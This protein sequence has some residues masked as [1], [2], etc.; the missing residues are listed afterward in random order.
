MSIDS[1]LGLL[2]TSL[3]GAL[4]VLSTIVSSIS[5]AL[6]FIVAGF[7]I[8]IV[9]Q[10]LIAPLRGSGSSDKAIS[11]KKGNG[12]K[13]SKVTYYDSNSGKSGSFRG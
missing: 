4:G 12:S 3:D 1:V 8:F 11:T 7:S 10:L 6:E 2:G 9:T 13:K 5:G